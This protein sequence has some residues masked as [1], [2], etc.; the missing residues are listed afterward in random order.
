MGKSVYSVP[1]PLFSPQSAGV[2]AKMNQNK[3]QLITDFDVPLK[4]LFPLGNAKTM[5]A[6]DEHYANF[7]ELQ[8]ALL[9]LFRTKASLGL[10]EI[11][12]LSGEEYQTILQEL[13]FLELAKVIEETAPGIYS[14][15]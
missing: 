15:K 7:S 3:L 12:A 5:T 11:V 10:Q 6:K 14:K 8:N 9:Q 2:F 13:T 4:K 1:A